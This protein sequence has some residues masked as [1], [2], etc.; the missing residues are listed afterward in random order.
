MKS[1]RTLALA[2]TVFAAVV[3]TACS[4]ATRSA[5]I[6]SEIAP[7]GSAVRLHV[8]NN[9]FADMN[10]FVIDGG[11]RTRVGFVPGES[12]ADLPLDRW[13][14][15]GTPMRLVASPIG[16]GGV[17]ASDPVTLFGGETVTFTIQPDLVTSY[18]SVR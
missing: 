12:A 18:A 5:D 15:P 13:Y 14:R 6:A 17:A 10:V 4:R 8:N 3:T 7:V 1:M 16:G 9:H 11:M 2:A